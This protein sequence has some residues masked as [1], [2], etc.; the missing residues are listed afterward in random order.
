MA[1]ITANPNKPAHS[2]NGAVVG[3]VA[4]PQQIRIDSSGAWRGGD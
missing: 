3:M 2:N 4:C 1:L